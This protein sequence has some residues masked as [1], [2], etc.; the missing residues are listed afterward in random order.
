[1]RI[2]RR[3]YLWQ[4]TE[5]LGEEGRPVLFLER[6]KHLVRQVPKAHSLVPRL[7][8]VEDVREALCDGLVVV[9][10]ALEAQQRANKRVP[11]PYGQ[12]GES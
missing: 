1:M 4:S 12:M 3:A 6:V 2:L 11:F 10:V 9:I 5:R 7:V 8:V